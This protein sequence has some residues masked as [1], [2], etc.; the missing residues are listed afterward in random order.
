MAQF[1]GLRVFADPSRKNKRKALRSPCSV[2]RV[3]LS[4]RSVYHYA[5]A[6]VDAVTYAI[7]EPRLF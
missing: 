7:D 6:A 2:L 1:G 3:S 5:Q 4:L